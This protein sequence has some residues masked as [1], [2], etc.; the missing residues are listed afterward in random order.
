MLLFALNFKLAKNS[1]FLK[2]RFSCYFPAGFAPALETTFVPLFPLF[3]II[4]YPIA[5]GSAAL[6]H[7]AFLDLYVQIKG[8]KGYKG[9]IRGKIVYPI[10]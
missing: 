8:Y 7:T 10:T 4:S 6:Q 1:K 5:P 3:P 9:N 2:N